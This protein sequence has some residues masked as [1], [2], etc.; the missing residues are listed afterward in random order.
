MYIESPA[1]GFQARVDSEGRVFT[2]SDCSSRTVTTTRG[3]YDNLSVATIASALSGTCSVVIQNQGAVPLRIALAATNPTAGDYEIAAG[4][5]FV[6]PFP[7]SGEIRGEG[8]GGAGGFV[9]LQ[10]RQV[11]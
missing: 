9:T 5:T 8:V 4:A 1:D 7:Y 10:A 6:V 2:K 11:S 3:S